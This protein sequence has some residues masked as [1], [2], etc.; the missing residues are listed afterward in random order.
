MRSG[1]TALGGSCTPMAFAYITPSAGGS[2]GSGVLTTSECRANVSKLY[3]DRGGCHVRGRTCAGRRRRTRRASAGYDGRGRAGTG[4]RPDVLDGDR[5]ELR[6][7]PGQR[8]R[9]QYR[10][11]RAD[12]RPRRA[13]DRLLARALRSFVPGGG[14][15]L[16][17]PHAGGASRHRHLR[18][19]H[20]LH[21]N[22]VP[23]RWR[24]LSRPWDSHPGVLGGA[25]LRRRRFRPGGCWRCS[26]WRSYSS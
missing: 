21:R 7:E 19:R 5:S 26:S 13:G 12:R 20:L 24:D 23:W 14:R 25:H 15:R 9:L 4:D 16:R 18:C 6:L 10:P 22:T 2:S 17:V 11:E 8:R 3:P 1:E